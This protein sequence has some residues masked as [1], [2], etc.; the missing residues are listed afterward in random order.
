MCC[1]VVCECDEGWGGSGHAGLAGLDGWDW[2][3][4]NGGCSVAYFFL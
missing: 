1:D 3:P 2:S 4:W